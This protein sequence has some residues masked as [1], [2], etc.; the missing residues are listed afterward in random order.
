MDIKL[1]FS[2][3]G[4]DTKNVY[5]DLDVYMEYGYVSTTDRNHAKI[6]YNLF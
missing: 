4:V 5:D 2:C 6:M 1:R 3:Y